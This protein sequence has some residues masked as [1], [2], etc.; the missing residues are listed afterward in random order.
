MNSRFIVFPVLLFSAICAFQSFASSE[1]ETIVD[2]FEHKSSAVVLIAVESPDGDRIGSG[3]AISR[4]GK[5]VTNYH[6]LKDARKVLVKLKNGRA[7]LPRRIVNVDAAKDIAVIQIDN[8]TPVYFSL[9]DSNKV[10]VG[11]RVVT[12]G[13]PQGLESTVADGLISSVRLNE[14]G[15][16]I[17]QISVPLSN[18]S[19]GGPLINL[20]GEVIGITTAAMAD[21]ENLN[22]AVPINYLR[23]L[24][25]KPFRPGRDGPMIWK[26]EQVNI[27]PAFSRGIDADRSIW[28]VQKGDTLYGIS[29][30]VNVPIEEIKRLNGLKGVRIFPGQRLRLPQK[31]GE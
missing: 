3:F 14:A 10:T 22:F 29:K 6:V 18:G 13:N 15:M 26:S 8:A 31:R 20:K 19:S 23:I 27:Q 17:F 24:L 30:K 25:R 4:D 1:S 12:I 9:G 21:G 16:K 5:I 7:Y 28:V 2:I 11:E